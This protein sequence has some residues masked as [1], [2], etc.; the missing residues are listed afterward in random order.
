MPSAKTK[1]NPVVVIVSALLFAM[2]P[3]AFAISGIMDDMIDEYKNFDDTLQSTDPAARLDAQQRGYMSGGGVR[4]RMDPGGINVDS[5]ISVQDPTFTASCSGIDAHLGSL[6]WISADKIIEQFKSLADPSVAIYALYLSMKQM[7]DSCASVSSFIQEQIIDR[8]DFLNASC[9]DAANMLSDKVGDP[10]VKG[11]ESMISDLTSGNGGEDAN[12][13]HGQDHLLEAAKD[14]ELVDKNLL[15]HHLE[16]VDFTS[17]VGTGLDKNELTMIVMSLAGAKVQR[18]DESKPGGGLTYD[19]IPSSVPDIEKL[20]E[21]GVLEGIV[22]EGYSPGDSVS[23][24]NCLNS[25][26]GIIAKSE[27][28]SGD[29]ISLVEIV[30]Q[31]LSTSEPNSLVNRFAIHHDIGTHQVTTPQGETTEWAEMTD[32]EFGFIGRARLPVLALIQRF[33]YTQ[34]T[35][36]PQAWLDVI[37][38]RFAI[39]A[40]YRVMREAKDAAKMAVNNIDARD[41]VD[42]SE[43]SENIDEAWRDIQAQ[44]EQYAQKNMSR[45]ANI[46]MFLQMSG[47]PRN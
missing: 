41:S 7:C 42:M 12:E 30:Q 10:M 47:M 28:A 2:S 17:A 20:A 26:Q 15:L 31:F 4:V 34:G 38:K 46:D 43:V 16:D 6:S 5:W 29:K 13:I 45:L 19:D 1:I 39:D 9:E 27:N 25:E 21:E 14:G 22:C 33:A 37:A 44:R 24:T 40:A 23:P 8:L 18:V 35:Q 36:P 11:A 3:A 32:Q